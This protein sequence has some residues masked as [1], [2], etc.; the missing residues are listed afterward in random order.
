MINKYHVSIRHIPGWGVEA[1]PENEPTYPMKDWTGD[2]HNR[3][4][5][6]RA[7]Q[8]PVK[9]E[10]LHSNERPNVTRVFG[11]T[12]PPSGLSGVIRRFA[13]KYSENEWTHWLSLIMAYR[14]NMIEGIG[15]DLSRAVAKHDKKEFAKLVLWKVIM[16]S[17]VVVLFRS[18][19][20]RKRR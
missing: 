18:R 1:D 15:R 7:E 5:Y 10:I 6:E 14:I 9:V 11:T 2:D 8:Q 16:I 19:S 4:N 13:F 17:A 12:A 20:R 3:S